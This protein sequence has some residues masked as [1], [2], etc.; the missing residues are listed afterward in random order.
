LDHKGLE[1]SLLHTEFNHSEFK[2]YGH[3]VK[4]HQDWV[5]VKIEDQICKFN[6]SFFVISWRSQPKQLKL[7]CTM[8]MNPGHMQLFISWN[9]I[10]FENLTGIGHYMVINR[11]IIKMKIDF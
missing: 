2:C 11:K 9:A 3:P 7:C 5:D 6:V 4:G 8:W 10:F 1:S